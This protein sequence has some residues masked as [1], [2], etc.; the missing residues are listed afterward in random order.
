MK[1]AKEKQHYVNNQDFL[2][3]IINYKAKVKTAALKEV[4]SLADMDDEEQFAF[5]KIGKV[6]TN[7][8]G[9]LYW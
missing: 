1:S 3:A 9:K 2:E 5:L 7:L 4:P 8:S 6:L